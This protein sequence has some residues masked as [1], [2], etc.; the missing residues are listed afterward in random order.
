MEIPVFNLKKRTV[1]KPF[2]GKGFLNRGHI[3]LGAL[4]I[5]G[6][7]LA[8]VQN[9]LF[10]HSL[11]EVFSIV[12]ACSIFFVTWNSRKFLD[13]HFLLFLGIACFFVAGVD[14][15]HLL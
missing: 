3:V 15:L 8:S 14:F 4:T 13:N 6:L 11:A 9:Y 10:F 12:I 5:L 1:L 7:Y 2:V